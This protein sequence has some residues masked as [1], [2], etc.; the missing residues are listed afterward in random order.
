MYSGLLTFCLAIAPPASPRLAE[1]LD[2]SLFV[3][4]PTS[5]EVN[6]EERSNVVERSFDELTSSPYLVQPY[7]ARK[8][9]SSGIPVPDTP[10]RQ[11]IEAVY[12]RFL[13]ATAGIK[14]A[15]KGYESNN[16]GAVSYTVGP[17]TPAPPRDHRAFNS[18]RRAMRPPV[19][20]EELKRQS[21]SVDELGIMTY[22]GPSSPPVAN[23]TITLVRRAFKAMVPGKT[24]SRRLSRVN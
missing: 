5:R 20:S 4:S 10:S 15:G 7:P 21:V 17:S 12:D 14:R 11:K 2:R 18:A 6:E 13:M 19:S 16:T 23:N 24:V 8:P 22:A 9:T 3:A 1:V